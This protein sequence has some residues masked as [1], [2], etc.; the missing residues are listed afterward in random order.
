MKPIPPNEVIDLTTG[1]GGLMHI[2]AFLGPA[3]AQVAGIDVL[4]P[5]AAERREAIVIRGPR[6]A[7]IAKCGG[8]HLPS[9]GTCMRRLS[10]DAGPEQQWT[11]PAINDGACALYASQERYGAL[12]AAGE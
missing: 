10:L 11:V 1:S 8:D 3:L 5:R 2:S 12:Y 9:C 4:V 6:R 7:D